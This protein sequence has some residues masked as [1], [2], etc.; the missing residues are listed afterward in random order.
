MSET[1]IPFSFNYAI[2][3]FEKENINK[4]N[5]KTRNVLTNYQLPDRTQ[6]I[7]LKFM[8]SVVTTCNQIINIEKIN[9][10][11]SKPLSDYSKE[12]IDFFF[13]VKSLINAF[14]INLLTILNDSILTKDIFLSYNFSKPIFIVKKRISLL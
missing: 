13:S 3:D 1:K 4:R 10:S 7:Q 5:F 11:N 9:V 12:A 2:T 8:S 6:T 14:D